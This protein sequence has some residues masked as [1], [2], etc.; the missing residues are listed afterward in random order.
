ML[1]LKK[2]WPD[3]VY[4]I[5]LAILSVF[6]GYNQYSDHQEHENIKGDVQK[7]V[8]YLTADDGDMYEVNPEMAHVDLLQ[9]DGE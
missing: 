2:N 4:K 6:L 7:I 8:G 3:L 5:I 9:L 1:D